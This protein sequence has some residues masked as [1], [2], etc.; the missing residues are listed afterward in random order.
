MYKILAG[1]IADESV[2]LV[3]AGK[4][5]FTDGYF[6]AV[7]GHNRVNEVFVQLEV[8][9][10]AAKS[11]LQGFHNFVVELCLGTGRWKDVGPVAMTSE[12]PGGRS[13]AQVLAS[14]IGSG[15]SLP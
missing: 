3:T 5:P 4:M 15:S 10:Y 13:R 6:P 8:E 1:K 12:F 9:P 2:K 11:T 14:S 7:V